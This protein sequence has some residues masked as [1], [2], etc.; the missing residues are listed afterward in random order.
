MRMVRLEELG[1]PGEGTEHQRDPAV[2]TQVG[3]GLVAASRQIEIGHAIGHEDP[4]AVEP[5]G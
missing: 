1:R 2:L 3:R 4:Q 5:L